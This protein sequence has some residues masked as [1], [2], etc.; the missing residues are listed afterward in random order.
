LN[1]SVIPLKTVPPKHGFFQW[2]SGQYGYINPQG[3]IDWS[4]NRPPDKRPLVARPAGSPPPDK[5]GMPVLPK[6]RPASFLDPTYFSN[7]S[8]QM[9]EIQRRMLEIQQSI[10]QARSL[11]NTGLEQ[12]DRDLSNRAASENASLAARGFGRSGMAD[13]TTKER[14]KDYLSAKELLGQQHGTA[15]INRLE[16]QKVQAMDALEA[17]RGAEAS[18]A[19]QRFIAEQMIRG[20]TEKEARRMLREAEA[21]QKGRFHKRGSTWFYTNPQGVTVSLGSATPAGVRA[22]RERARN[23][24]QGKAN[25]VVGG[26]NIL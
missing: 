8:R 26:V 20:K 5:Y 17:I 16:A 23:R 11:Y 7:I 15:A 14:E 2:G 13:T 19:K 18:D 22:Q 9:P 4:V 3:K 10:E 25:K 1:P 21:P 24:K 6:P 12:L